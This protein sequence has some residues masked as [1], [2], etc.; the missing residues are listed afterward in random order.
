[1]EVDL[2]EMGDE[3][4]SIRSFL[5]SKLKV[6]ITLTGNKALVNSENI[7]QEKLKRTVNK[8]VYH[9]N[10][11][12]KYWVSLKGDAIKINKFKDAKKR[13]KRKKKTTPPSIIKHGW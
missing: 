7:S 5:S 4:E 3:R 12:N 1:L 2:S 11:M 10:L 13:E 9:R 8:F 6:N